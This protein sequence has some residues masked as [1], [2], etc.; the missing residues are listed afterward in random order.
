MV[1]PLRCSVKDALSASRAGLVKFTRMRRPS[2]ACRKAVRAPD[3]DAPGGADHGLALASCRVTAVTAVTAAA[4][5]ATVDNSVGPAHHLH[6]DYGRALG[7][8]DLGVFLQAAPPRTRIKAMA[9]WHQARRYAE[10]R[11]FSRSVADCRRQIRRL[12]S[13]R[14]PDACHCQSA[15][16]D[17][18]HPVKLKIWLR[19]SFAL[20]AMQRLHSVLSSPADSPVGTHLRDICSSPQAEDDE[21]AGFSRRGGRS[22]LEA[23][24][25]ARLAN[26]RDDEPPD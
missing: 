11:T 25:P 24:H 10:S 8:D 12:Q 17:A 5:E 2:E 15:E 22:R 3:R 19:H 6:F 4:A 20:D 16:P 21:I 1:A 13:P 9:P 14:P 18:R 7:D 23:A 26:Q